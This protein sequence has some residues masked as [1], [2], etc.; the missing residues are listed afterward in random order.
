VTAGSAGVACGT[1][2]RRRVP[3]LSLAMFVTAAFTRVRLYQL[4]DRF[5]RP[6]SVRALATLA[7]WCRWACPQ[8]GLQ[9]QVEGVVRQDCCLYVSNHRTYLDIPVLTSVLGATFLSRA[10]V[11]TWPLVGTLARLTETVL[12]ER[13]DPRDRLRAARTLMRR[14][15]TSSVVVFPEGTTTGAALPAPFHPGPFRLVQ[16]LE[17]PVV[18]VTLRYSDR[19]AYWVDDLTTWQHLTTRVFNGDPLRVAVHIGSPVR[20]RDCTDV[21]QLAAAVYAAVCRPIETYGELV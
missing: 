18:P 5:R 14:L 15:R 11:V 10:D 8:L 1:L 3:Y 16:R 2:V 9:V 19:R 17:V 4:A 7:H 6:S 13:D 12:V 20:S 21:E